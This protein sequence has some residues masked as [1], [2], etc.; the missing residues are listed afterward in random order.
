M[1][2]EIAAALQTK[3]YTLLQ[4]PEAAHYIPQAN[5]LQ[6]GKSAPTAIEAATTKATGR[7]PG[8]LALGAGAVHAEMRQRPRYRRRRPDRPLAEG[9]AGAAVGTVYFLM[10]TDPDQGAHPRRRQGEGESNHSLRQGN[11]GG[12]AGVVRR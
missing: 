2:D 10:I 4:D 7:C 6:V 9:I 12:G 1:N 8:G 3:G 11:S 5:I